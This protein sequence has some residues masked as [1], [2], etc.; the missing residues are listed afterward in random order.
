MPAV[1]FSC[2][3]SRLQV[4]LTVCVRSRSARSSAEHMS[5]QVPT[6]QPP[7]GRCSACQHVLGSVATSHSKRHYGQYVPK[8]VFWKPLRDDCPPS[9]QLHMQTESKAL[10][11]VAAGCGA[12]L[13]A[14]CCW[15]G[16]SPTAVAKAGRACREGTRVL[17]SC[18]ARPATALPHSQGRLAQRR[19]L[20]CCRSG[21]TAATATANE[22]WHACQCLALFCFRVK[23]LLRL[24]LIVIQ[25]YIL[26]SGFGRLLLLQLVL[27][28]SQSLL[29]AG[30]L[31]WEFFGLALLSLLL[32]LNGQRSTSS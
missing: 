9:L 29:H 4:R 13:P 1:P 15:H 32:H 16:V 27:L 8:L 20:I 26:I 25:V 22:C 21:S 3:F 11:V 18:A 6:I 12:V 14:G 30:Q 7:P 28:L 24:P 31:L 17:V 19:R 2:N 10:T 5:V 23:H